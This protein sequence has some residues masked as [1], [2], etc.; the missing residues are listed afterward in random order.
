MFLR[1]PALLAAVLLT[2]YWF[3]VVVKL[4]RLGRKLGKDP[5][6]LPR[7]RVGILLRVAWYPCIAALLAGLWITASQSPERLARSPMAWLVG[8][9]I[10]TEPPPLWWQVAVIPASIFCFLCTAFT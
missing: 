4:I 3:W 5:N 1:I 2:I 9:L 10:P 8:W 7:E 6:A